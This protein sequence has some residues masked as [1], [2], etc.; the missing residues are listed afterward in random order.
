MRGDYSL[1]FIGL[2]VALLISI[3]TARSYSQR[4]NREQADRI[5]AQGEIRQK[6]DELS[7]FR[8]THAMAI[9][10]AQLQYKKLVD[11]LRGLDK[12]FEE[13]KIQFPWLVIAIADLHALEAKRDAQILETKKHPAVKAAS[14]VRE[15]G[16]KRR[17]AERQFRQARYRVDYY[18]KLF[19][20]ITEYIG[21][22]V[23]DEAV[24]LSGSKAEPTDDP[25]KRWLNDAEFQ[26][27]ST[28]QKNQLALDRWKSSRK[29]LWE[30]GRDYERFIGYNYETLGYDVIFTGAI[31]G[32]EDMGRD[33]IA[34]RDSE[35]RIIQ[36]KYWSQQKIIHE[37]HIFQL[38]GSTLEYAFRLGHF[39]KLK[40]LSIF[41]GQ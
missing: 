1:W 8:Q 31:H 29:S 26:K 33:L 27:L 36:C 13:R 21:D 38:F 14:A 15:H 9:A 20:W 11:Y 18:E 4:A 37:K 10:A 2:V 7:Q 19:P 16:S 25:V 30:I 32:F 17:D 28:S 22:D 23:P 41:G 24:D 39:D 34:R 12:I 35:L 5:K 40:Q 3:L 6:N